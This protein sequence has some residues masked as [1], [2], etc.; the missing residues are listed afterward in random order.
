MIVRYTFAIA[1]VISVDGPMNCFIDLSAGWLL[2]SFR[3]TSSHTRRIDALQG[4]IWESLR[5]CKQFLLPSNLR[6]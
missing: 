5:V 3:P 2:G 1:H 6:G 4:E